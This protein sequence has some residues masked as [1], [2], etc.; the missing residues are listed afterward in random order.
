MRFF[1]SGGED[2]Y[3][4]LGL[5]RGASQDEIKAAYRKQALKWHP[6]RNQDN[7]EKAE[8]QFKKVSEAYQVLSGQSAGPGNHAAGGMGGMGGPGFGGGRQPTQ[9]EAEEIFKSFFGGNMAD[10][11][12]EMMKNQGGQQ[13]TARGGRRGAA[14]NHD[15]IFGSMFGGGMG[16]NSQTSIRQEVVQ[17]SDG[18]QVLRVTK[19]TVSG[20]KTTTEVTEQPMSQNSQGPFGF[21]GFGGQSKEEQDAFAQQQKIL[22]QQIKDAAKGAVKEL[23]KQAA[24]SAAKAA[25]KALK[26]GLKNAFNKLLGGK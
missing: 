9:E 16:M 6:D 20:G 26:N 13:G 1:Y 23:G 18:S 12:N 14:G 21:G 22:E 17:K 11:M 24:R 19:T 4:V 5:T 10:I 7:R 15:D 25:K 2:Y 3:K 8:E